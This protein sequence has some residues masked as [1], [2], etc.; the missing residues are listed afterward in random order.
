MIGTIGTNMSAELCWNN[1]TMNSNMGGADRVIRLILAAILVGLYF[2]GTVAGTTGIV[3][4][5]FAAVF[6]LTSTIAFCPLYT[7][8]GWRTRKP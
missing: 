6:A 2:S 3:L 5:V 8:F 7:A 4:M 1:R